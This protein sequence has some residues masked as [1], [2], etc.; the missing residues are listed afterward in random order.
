MNGDRL[1]ELPESLIFEIL[2]LLTI[3]EVVR[4]SLVSRRWKNLWKTVP[5]LNF[6]DRKKEIGTERVGKFIAWALMLWR[7]TRIQTLKIDFSIHRNN[8]LYRDINFLMRFAKEYEVEQLVVFLK[9]DRYFIQRSIDIAGSIQGAKE[10]LY[11]A[12]QCLY[13][14]SSI[15]WLHLKGCNLH[16]PMNNV[17][18]NWLKYLRIDGYVVSQ[19]LINKGSIIN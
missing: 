15:K 12:S 14:C 19:D 10:E 7:G 18:W 16:T 3:R 2:R 11:W 6:E 5:F 13:S 17:S 9:Y 8:S 4:T 1:S